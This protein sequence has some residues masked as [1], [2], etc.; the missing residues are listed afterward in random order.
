MAEGN[1]QECPEERRNVLRKAGS[2]FSKVGS[3]HCISMTVTRER[4]KVGKQ[5]LRIVTKAEGRSWEV[6]ELIYKTETDSQTLKTNLWLLKGKGGGRDKFG[7]W[8]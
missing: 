6:N 5:L 7:V 3:E 2:P 8:D 1:P 4:E